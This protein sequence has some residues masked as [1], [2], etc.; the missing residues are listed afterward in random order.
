VALPAGELLD[1]LIDSLSAHG[2]AVVVAPTIDHVAEK[3]ERDEPFVAIV[4]DSSAGWLREV[5]DLLHERPNARPLAL[6]DVE[7][8]AELLAAVGAG[9]TGFVSPR[10]DIVAILRTVREVFERGAAIPRGLVP[11]LVDEVRRGRGRSVTTAAGS[12][13]V[14]EREWEI[15]L[16]LLQR[17]STREIAEMLFVSVGTVRTHISALVRKLGATDREDTIRL[18]ERRHG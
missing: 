11:T 6:V 17:R 9:A 1:Q 2:F 7:S 12:I 14:T 8:P 18:L 15:L 3:F 13:D 5:S 10:A 4:D 16:L